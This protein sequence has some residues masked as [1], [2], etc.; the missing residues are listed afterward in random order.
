MSVTQYNFLFIKLSNNIKPQCFSEYQY[1]YDYMQF[2]FECEL[3][4]RPLEGAMKNASSMTGVWGI[5]LNM[6]MNLTLDIFPS[7]VAYSI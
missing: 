5:S 6:T 1:S 2:A 3:A 7:K 4:L